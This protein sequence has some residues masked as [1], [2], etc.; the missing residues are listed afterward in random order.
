MT[1]I[2]RRLCR[3]LMNEGAATAFG[4]EWKPLI[5][6]KHTWKPGKEAKTLQAKRQWATLTLNEDGTFEAENNSKQQIAGVWNVFAGEDEKGRPSPT[7]FL[8]LE[9]I[10][11]KTKRK[12]AL[13]RPR[14]NFGVEEYPK[15]LRFTVEDMLLDMDDVEEWGRPGASISTPE[16]FKKLFTGG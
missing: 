6:V 15:F 5:G 12:K 8:G 13:D 7:G 10:N 4:N 2:L 11:G 1:E 16:I 3:R 14:G 9:A